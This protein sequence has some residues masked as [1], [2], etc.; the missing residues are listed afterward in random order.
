VKAVG[1]RWRAALV[2][3]SPMVHKQ[4]PLLRAQIL[5]F[6]AKHCVGV[7]IGFVELRIIVKLQNC[8][9]YCIIN[10]FYEYY[11]RGIFLLE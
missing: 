11:F 7:F 10:P 3:A 4:L 6:H 5:R 1:L 8:I 2:V 9:R